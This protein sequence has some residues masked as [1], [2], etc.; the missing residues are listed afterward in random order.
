MEHRRRETNRARVWA[1]APS[2]KC[3]GS[4]HWRRR[5]RPSALEASSLETQ[6][7]ELCARRRAGHAR[8]SRREPLIGFDSTEPSAPMRKKRSG[9]EQQT[10]KAPPAAASRSPPSAGGAGRRAGRSKC[11]KAAYGAGLTRRRARCSASGEGGGAA[12]GGGARNWVVRQT[13]YDSPRG[14]QGCRGGGA[15]PWAPS[16]T[17]PALTLAQQLEDALDVRRV[18]IA[19]TRA[20]E[21]SRRPPVQRLTRRRRPPRRRSRRRS[22][23]RR[24]ALG[25]ASLL[26]RSG[27]LPQPLL[28]ALLAP[29]SAGVAEADCDHAPCGVVEG[30]VAV[31]EEPERLRRGGCGAA[32]C[33]GGGGQARGGEGV[34]RERGASGVAAEQDGSQSRAAAAPSGPTLRHAS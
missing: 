26:Q 1:N 17:R 2:A 25:Q 4:R 15:H 10:L 20:L 8:A 7:L 22:A 19:A 24:V 12:R 29:L 30:E 27:R 5:A 33:P 9:E 21:A 13:S 28:R 32:A 14:G 3:A 6:G 23:S 11:K 16:H 34:H 18:L 31:R